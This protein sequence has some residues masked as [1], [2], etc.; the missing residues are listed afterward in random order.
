[1]SGRRLNGRKVWMKMPWDAYVWFADWLICSLVGL[2]KNN[3]PL[4]SVAHAQLKWNKWLSNTER[5]KVKV[6]VTPILHSPVWGM[7]FHICSD[8][9]TNICFLILL[10]KSWDRAGPWLWDCFS[11]PLLCWDELS[12]LS[13]TFSKILL[14]ASCWRVFG[15][16]SWFLPTVSFR[17][18]KKW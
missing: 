10:C 5:N 9:N 18:R 6:K 3:L 2:L 8:T 17:E 14:P 12:P 1:M 13:Q 15:L 4:F 16:D 7:F 11:C